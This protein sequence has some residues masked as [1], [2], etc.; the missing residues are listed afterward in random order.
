MVSRVHYSPH[1][2]HV[3]LYSTQVER[4][5]RNTLPQ[6]AMQHHNL[7]HQNLKLNL[8]SQTTC[9]VFAALYLIA[10]G[11]IVFNPLHVMHS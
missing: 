2:V 10:S 8:T 4:N 7:Q 9:I 1:Y 6:A 5:T 3:A 11:V